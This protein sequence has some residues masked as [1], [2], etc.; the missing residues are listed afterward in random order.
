MN[1]NTSSPGVKVLDKAFALLEAVGASEQGRS[2]TELA[3]ALDLPTATVFRLMHH[4]ARLGYIEQEPG[5]KRYSLGLRVLTL[6]ASAIQSVRFAA[7][8]R[9]HLRD[10]MLATG[11]LAQLAVYRDGDIVYV[12]RVET[13]TTSRRLVPMGMR[14]PAHTTA[15]GKALLAALPQVELEGFLGRAPLETRTPNTLTDARGLKSHLQLV[16]ERGYAVDMEEAALG[17]WCVAAPIRDYSAR[18]VAAVS[19]SLNE[20][21]LPEQIEQLALQVTDC[22]RR[23]SQEAGYRPESVNAVLDLMVR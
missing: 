23:I 13:P 8:A 21:P 20:R 3:S 14:V 1:R 2:L 15:L 19:V 7:L 16:C 11:C 10:L 4:L 17:R 5:S 12:D 18:A 22:A 9:P 6:K